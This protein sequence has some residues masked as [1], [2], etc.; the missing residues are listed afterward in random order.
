MVD[1]G[2]GGE[3]EKSTVASLWEEEDESLQN[4]VTS[5]NEMGLKLS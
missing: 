2:S 4:Q 5:V 1:G 3:D